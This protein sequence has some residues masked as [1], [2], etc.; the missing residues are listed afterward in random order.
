MKKE[1]V[2]ATIPLLLC[3]AVGWV[4]FEA[5]P[6]DQAPAAVLRN[7]ILQHGT[8]RTGAV[9][10]VSSIYLGFRA[11]DTLG[12]TIVLFLAVSGALM[13]LGKKQ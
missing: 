13:Y 6:R 2:R 4:L 12:E 10:L 5:L 9:N 8:A 11:F 1:L 7:Y 3:L